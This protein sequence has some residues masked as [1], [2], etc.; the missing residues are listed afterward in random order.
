MTLRDPFID[1]ATSLPPSSASC[2]PS[3]EQ[4][5]DRARLLWESQGCPLG[6]S[7]ENTRQAELELLRELNPPLSCRGTM[8][9]GIPLEGGLRGARL[10]PFSPP[11]L[12][13]A[14]PLSPPT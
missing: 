5:A 1:P 8:T 3:P 2:R 14:R 10:P 9:V 6:R 13:S 11:R 7:I 12:P 4:I